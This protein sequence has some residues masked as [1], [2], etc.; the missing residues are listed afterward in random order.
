MANAGKMTVKLSD[1]PD[2]ADIHIGDVL[3]RGRK[4][5]KVIAVFPPRQVRTER[6]MR[7]TDMITREE[8]EIVI[9]E[10]FRYS[11]VNKDLTIKR[12]KGKE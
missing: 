4:K 9:T 5:Y 11:D 7:R 6:I 3:T 1:P 10:W 2:Y 8:K 12:D